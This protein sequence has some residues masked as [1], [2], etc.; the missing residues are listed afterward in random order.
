[1]KF[2]YD[3]KI[4]DDDSIYELMVDCGADDDFPEY[5]SDRQSAWAVVTA[6]RENRLEE[7]I[8]DEYSHYVEDFIHGDYTDYDAECIEE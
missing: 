8:A 5:F 1:M 3:E 6:T 4:Y 7:M 2:R